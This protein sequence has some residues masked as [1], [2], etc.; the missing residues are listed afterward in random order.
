M[1]QVSLV[2]LY[3]LRAA[4]LLLVAG[5]GPLVW[6]T[7]FHHEQPW[8]LMEG[9]VNCMLAAMSALAVLGLRHPL[10]MLPLL[11]FEV[12]WKFIWL[13]VVA[14]PLWRAG[15]L[16]GAT[17]RVT[18]QCLGVVILLALIPWR[19]VF[20]SYVSGPGERWR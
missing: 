10:R 12:G 18:V 14:Y 3:T 16:E 17:W 13:A 8:G 20:D 11:L 1:T 7:V 9:V 15:T 19:Y 6:P 5:L 4:Y 2:R